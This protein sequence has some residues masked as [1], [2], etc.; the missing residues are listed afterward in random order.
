MLVECGSLTHDAWLC[1]QQIILAL[2]H[3]T[4][5]KGHVHVLRANSH[6]NYCMLIH[7]APERH[8]IIIMYKR[9]CD[10]HVMSNIQTA[11]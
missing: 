1:S 10:V 5:C 9:Q 6:D 3:E 7:L 11:M 2:L 4:E 8:V